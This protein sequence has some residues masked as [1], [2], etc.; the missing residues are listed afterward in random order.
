MVNG[1][2]IT[3]IH[4][5]LA[6]RVYVTAEFTN[7]LD[8]LNTLFRLCLCSC[9]AE[10]LK[11][12]EK[13]S[14]LHWAFTRWMFTHWRMSHTFAALFQHSQHFQ[15]QNI[16]FYLKLKK[17]TAFFIQLEKCLEPGGS[18]SL[19]LRCGVWTRWQFISSWIVLVASSTL[20]SFSCCG[21][22]HSQRDRGPIRPDLFLLKHVLWQLWHQGLC[23]HTACSRLMLFHHI[24]TLPTFTQE[25]EK[26]V[27]HD[28]RS[29]R[30]KVWPCRTLIL[31]GVIFYQ[32]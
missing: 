26:C 10:T 24:S 27:R 6:N 12:C 30:P 15:F 5:Y 9:D 18:V 4:F 3:R 7:A 20:R 29:C 32:F 28:G 8:K 25:T 31:Y 14:W 1:S 16:T 21:E 23:K 11:P 17:E 13:Q 19:G 22:V 2:P